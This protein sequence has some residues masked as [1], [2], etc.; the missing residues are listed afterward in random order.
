MPIAHFIVRD[1]KTVFLAPRRAFHF[2]AFSPSNGSSEQGF[3][4]FPLAL[5]IFTGASFTDFGDNHR[6]GVPLYM[7]IFHTEL[8][9]G[10]TWVT[11]RPSMDC[12]GN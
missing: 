2:L 7:L 5:A 9:R 10:W 12:Q 4:V 3:L 11:T 8:T 6:Y 1:I